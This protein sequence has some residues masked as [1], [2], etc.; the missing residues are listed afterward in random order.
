MQPGNPYQTGRLS[1]VD[2]HQ[3]IILDQLIFMLIMLFTSVAGAYPSGAVYCVP[4][5]LEL[6]SQKIILTSSLLRDRV[7]QRRDY[8]LLSVNFL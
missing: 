1:T 3:L 8:P 6:H 4:T 5:R 7:K 2:L